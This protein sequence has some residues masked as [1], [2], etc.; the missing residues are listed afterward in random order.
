RPSPRSNGAVGHLESDC[1]ARSSSTLQDRKE[2]SVYSRLHTRIA[3]FTVCLSVL[4][5]VPLR[6]Q[7]VTYVPYIQPGDNGPFGPTDQMVVTW[8]TDETVP[9]TSAYSVEFGTSLATLMPAAVTGR[10][11]DNYL[12][13]D[14]QFSGLSLP[15]KYGAHSNYTAVLS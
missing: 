2:N 8:Q 6:A 5:V 12:S 11:V 14:P 9:V 1:R 10:V 3:F 13:A 4:L 15:F 7:T